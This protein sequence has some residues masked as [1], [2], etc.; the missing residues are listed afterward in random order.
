MCCHLVTAKTRCSFPWF[1]ILSQHCI[2]YVSALPLSVRW[3]CLPTCLI[4]REKIKRVVPASLC[5]LR[6][7][8]TCT[9]VTRLDSFP[10]G[11][12]VGCSKQWV[13]WA[14]W[15][16]SLRVRG[17]LHHALR[18]LRFPM[19]DPTALIVEHGEIF[20]HDILPKGANFH[21][22]WQRVDHIY[23]DTHPSVSSSNSCASD[24]INF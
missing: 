17:W 1:V 11:W 22:F 10:G 18:A 19:A 14:L 8:S 16:R 7:T 13:G 2:R 23:L 24:G 15:G 5:Q 9:G 6:R 12:H 20:V 4:Q 21:T 3:R